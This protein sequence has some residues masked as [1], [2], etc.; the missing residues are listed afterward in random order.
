[1]KDITA[2]I[3]PAITSTET[4]VKGSRP[5]CPA[6]TSLIGKITGGSVFGGAFYWLEDLSSQPPTIEVTVRGS[7]IHFAIRQ[8]GGLG[9]YVLHKKV[10]IWE[11]TQPRQHVL[12]KWARRLNSLGQG[13]REGCRSGLM[14][15]RHCNPKV[16]RLKVWIIAIR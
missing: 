2:S 4:D 16:R 15:R 3:E 9:A 12:G 8:R 1:M 11:W 5:D 13:I 14:A 6:L 10:V 7:S